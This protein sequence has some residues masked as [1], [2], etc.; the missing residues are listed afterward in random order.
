MELNSEL[1][2]LSLIILALLLLA[3]KFIRLKISILQEYFIPSSIIAGF[4]GLILGPHVLG[5]IYTSWIGNEDAYLSQGLFPEEMVN[6]WKDLASLLV[7]VIFAALFLGKEIPSFKKI[8]NTAGPQVTFGQTVAWGQYVVGISLAILVLV[9]L[10]DLNP[11]AGALIEIS[12]EGGIG[13]ATGLGSTFAEHG[14]EDGQDLAIGLATIGIL[15]GL[16]IG[17]I[18]LN[19]G[20]RSNKSQ[21]IQDP[22]E[23][24]DQAL[25]G[26]FKKE[27][28]P[29][30]GEK[31][32]RSASIGTLTI[33]L[34]FLG[35]AIS[36]GIL[37]LE[38]LRFVEVNTWEEWTGFALMEHFPLFPLAMIGSIIVQI[39]LDRYIDYPI[40]N[41]ELMKGISGFALDFMIVS[42]I[43]SLAIT[44]IGTHI[45]PF[46]LLAI[47]GIAWN[48]A[49]FYF[50]AQKI[51]PD[52]WFERGIG[53]FGQSMGMT[54]IGLL[55]MRIA[56]P[57]DKSPA[58]I[59]FA[60]KQLMF[61]PIVGGGFFTA[62]SAP[63]IAQMGPV[64]VL[65]ICSLLFLG[66]LL[67]G[68]FYFGRGKGGNSDNEKE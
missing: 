40:I 61:E 59:S 66:W 15:F 50:L 37:L 39:F 11:I 16:I 53:D 17:I 6:I 31:T 45:I 49:A 19:W 22:E 44:T 1:A 27:D 51:M 26:I 32:T 41:Q 62:A 7:T 24:S 57:E 28:R 64:P 43:A 36:L 20:A 25:K 46:I 14:F 68:L 23:A 48:V 4:V 10:F 54:A 9:P 67:L 12:F 56:D 30:A 13:S 47:A 33:H 35:L 52:Y 65:I 34:S 21:L 60:Y 63:L 58:T 42:A 29:T 55:M 8:W 3:G 18:L 2:G 38:G 5:E